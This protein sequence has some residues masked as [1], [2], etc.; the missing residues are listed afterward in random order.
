VNNYLFLH[1]EILF[2]LLYKTLVALKY[3]VI[4]C[5][6]ILFFDLY[7]F[8]PSL[9]KL[10][11][12]ISSTDNFIRHN[13]YLLKGRPTR[14]SSYMLINIIRMRGTRKLRDPNSPISEVYRDVDRF[15]YGALTRQERAI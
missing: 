14:V 15:K 10:L 9:I 3:F 7:S 13:V 1:L 4:E 8:D 6:N 12:K 5:L 2:L 11:Y